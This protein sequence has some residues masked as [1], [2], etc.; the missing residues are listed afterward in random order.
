MNPI[1]VG[2]VSLCVCPDLSVHLFVWHK[3]SCSPA[4]LWTYYEAEDDLELLKL[5]PPA[6]EHLD[7]RH[8]LSSCLFYVVL[9]SNPGHSGKAFYHLSY[10]PSAPILNFLVL[11]TCQR[12]RGEC[13]HLVHRRQ[14]S[15]ISS[16]FS[17][18]VC[19]RI[20]SEISGLAV[21]L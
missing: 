14:L 2:Q 6:P 19:L 4:W 15:G 11:C 12:G 8:V 1:T 13:M 9:A 7:Y 20:S 17:L 16:L 5:L 21:V 10:I 3:V 18:C